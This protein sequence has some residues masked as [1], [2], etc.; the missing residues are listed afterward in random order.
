MTEST[1]RYFSPDYVGARQ[2]FREAVD[3]SGGRLDSL[4]LAATGPQG[5]DLTIDVAWLGS[6]KPRRVFIHS[7]GLH[8]VEAFAGSAIQL[9]RL[10]EGFP[11]L[12]EDAAIVLVHV[13]NP[14]GMA[15][16][17]RFNENNVD[18]NCNFR[19]PLDKTA[20]APPHWQEVDAFL[21]PPT[22]PSKDHFYPRTALLMV[23]YGFQSLKQTVAGG[24]ALNPK[25][26]FFVG[27]TVEEGTTKFQAYIQERL[28]SVER[29]VAIDVH[30]GL[31][32]YGQDRLLVDAAEERE[33]VNR[34]MRF[35]YGERLQQLN[36]DSVAYPVQ[37]AQHH[38][39]YRLFPR[40]SVY[41]ATQEFGTYNPLRVVKTLREEN[42]WHH[43]GAGTVDHPAKKLLVQVFNPNDVRW[44]ELILMRGGDVFRK[45]LAL[46]LTGHPE[47]E[48]LDA[49][50][51]LYCI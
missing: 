2:R 12:P 37:G 18:L 33:S 10:E 8:G 44:K 30:T 45:G 50:T 17:R 22:P 7:S 40:A 1:D 24:Q 51:P 29:I 9:Q 38:M 43:Y 46:A 23:R 6:K 28:T 39:Y 42:R 19:S 16:R 47:V 27:R 31:G 15:W 36:G 35:V 11:K 41:F 25:G 14:Y 13:L 34:A 26:L 32:S 20:S 21:N 3:A 5:D 49:G 48:S 4:K